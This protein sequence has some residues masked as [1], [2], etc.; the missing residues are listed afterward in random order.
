METSQ[1]FK[2]QEKQTIVAEFKALVGGRWGEIIKRPQ[3]QLSTEGDYVWGLGVVSVLVDRGVERNVWEPIHQALVDGKNQTYIMEVL[4]LDKEIRSIRGIQHGQKASRKISETFE[5]LIGAVWEKNRQIPT[6]LI[7]KI[8]PLVEDQIMK[9]RKT[10]PRSDLANL[11]P[12]ARFEMRR[13]SD[14]ARAVIVDQNSN[15]LVE[16]AVEA[17][18]IDRIRSAVARLKESLEK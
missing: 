16:G 3:V 12:G 17:K 11:S 10:D 15:V 18:R 2:E 7:S 8:I 14:G 6:S 1:A 5:A 4:G 9:T 13:D